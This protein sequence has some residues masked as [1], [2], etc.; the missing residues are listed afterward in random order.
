MVKPS[1]GF[2]AG[3]VSG[4]AIFGKKETYRFLS[5]YFLHVYPDR[6]FYITDHTPAAPCAEMSCKKSL[7]VV[8][9]MWAGSHLIYKSMAHYQT[10]GE[11]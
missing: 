4:G 1:C 11:N 3:S 7:G 10:M 6:M 5:I 2:L 8:H 9:T